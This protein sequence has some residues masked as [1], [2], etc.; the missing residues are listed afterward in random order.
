MSKSEN[1]CYRMD[2]NVTAII[3]P[4]LWLQLGCASDHVRRPSHPYAR[5]RSTLN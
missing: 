3:L 2:G 1:R 4:W 5:F